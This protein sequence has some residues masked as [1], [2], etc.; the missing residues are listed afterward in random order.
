METVDGTAKK[1]HTNSDYLVLRK[2]PE[3]QGQS[4][5]IIDLEFFS[6]FEPAWATDQLVKIFSI[7][8]KFSLRYSNF[9]SEKTDS[10][11]NKNFFQERFCINTK[12]SPIIEE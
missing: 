8:V 1:P 3:F 7:L 6:L 2:Y 9:R 5:E 12:C 11:S 10:P 4:N